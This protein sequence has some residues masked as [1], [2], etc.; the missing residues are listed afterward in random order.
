MFPLID[1]RQLLLYHKIKKLIKS[2][3]CEAYN[4]DGNFDVD[5]Q[6]NHENVAP[7]NKTVPAPCK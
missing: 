7:S 3:K 6:L 2:G 4:E 5:V 1:L